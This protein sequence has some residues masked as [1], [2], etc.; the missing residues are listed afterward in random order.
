M[1]H[2]RKH[3]VRREVAE[4]AAFLLTLVLVVAAMSLEYVP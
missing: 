3:Y 2:P 1:A 4:T